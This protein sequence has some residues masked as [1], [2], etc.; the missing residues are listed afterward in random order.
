MFAQPIATAA[1][2]LRVASSQTRTIPSDA[3]SASSRPSGLNA[4]PGANGVLKLP[5]L[6]WRLPKPGRAAMRRPLLDRQTPASPFSPT[7]TARLP[8]G[9]KMTRAARPSLARRTPRST[10]Q[11]SAP[12]LAIAAKN[13][14]SGLIAADSGY[15]ARSAAI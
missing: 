9:L 3:A 2:C 5:R 12:L 7:A 15:D 14:P 6:E 4:A 13:R 10:D 8:S 1:T 11:S